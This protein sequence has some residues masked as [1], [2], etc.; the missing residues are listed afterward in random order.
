MQVKKDILNLIQIADK[1]QGVNFREVVEGTS[2]H[3]LIP[4]NLEL[5]EDKELIE[6]LVASSKNFIALCNKTKRRF[7]GT[8]INEVSK[9]I[10]NEFVEEIRK[11]G[12]KNK[13]PSSNGIPKH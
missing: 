6:N 5:K 11:I 2:N 4:L 8:R 13:N 9:A 12:L 1:M 10:E 7:Y 3:K